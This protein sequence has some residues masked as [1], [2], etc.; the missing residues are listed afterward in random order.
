MLILNSGG[1]FNK[2][3]NKLNGELEVPYDNSAIERILQS[4]DSKFDIAGLIYK[5]SLDMTMSDRK[6]LASVIMESNDDTFIIVHGTDTMHL[7]AEFLAEIFDDRKI[8]FV[9]AMN[10]FEIDNVEA[11]LN[12]GMAIGF[13]R[14]TSEF[15]VYICMS[16]YIESWNKIEKNTK[17]GKFEVV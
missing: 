13:A 16:G 15:G 6:V 10:P 7:S 3:Y 17:F 12:L 11:S 5:D 1:T 4:V 14:G 2:K 9:G 8:V